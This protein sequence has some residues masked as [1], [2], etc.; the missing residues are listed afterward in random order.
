MFD[1]KI[2]EEFGVLENEE[3]YLCFDNGR[4]QKIED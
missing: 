1:Y 2:F 3:R 4:V